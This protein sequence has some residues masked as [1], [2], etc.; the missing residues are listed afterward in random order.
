MKR[1]SQPAALP[2]KIL[3]ELA[4]LTDDAGRARFLARRRG[5]R[6][7]SVV[8]QL[9]DAART[10]LRIDT[11]RALSLAEAAVTIARKLRDEEALGRSLRAKANAL[12]VIGD[13]R[14]ALECHE[15]ALR[16]FR[17]ARNAEEEART[18]NASIQPLILLGDYDRALEA[19]EGARKLFRHLDDKRRLAHVEINVGNLYH[20]QDRFEEG[21]SFY[22]R[23]Y[24]MLLP[25]N[26]S[27]GLAVALYNMSVCLI[28]LNDFPRALS[29]YQRAREVFVERGMTLLIGQADYNI[30]Y[31]YYL[32]GEYGRAIDML[33]ATRQKS[34]TNGDAHILALCY[35][36]LSDIYLELN[37][38]AEAGEAAHEGYNRF[39][40]LAMGYEEAKCLANEAIALSQHGK[41]LRALDLF[42]R[43]RKVF[44]REKNLVWPWLI[45]LYRALVLFNEGRL[46]EARSACERALGFFES[47][48]LPGKAVLC[49]LL[50][51]RIELQAGSPE[52]AREHCGNAIRRLAGLEM[53]ILSYQA[54]LLMGQAHAAVRDVE[55]AYA[56]YQKAREAL[57]TLRSSLR[58]DE[59]KIAFMKNKSEV[60]ECLVAICLGGD[61]REPAFREAFGYIELAKSR[62][63]TEMILEGAQGSPEDLVC[64]SELVRRIRDMREELNWYYHRIELEQLRPAE[65]TPARIAQLQ[66]ATQAREKDLLRVLRELPAS[67]PETAALQ[68]FQGIPLDSIQ[69]QLPDDTSLIEYFTVGDQVIAA[70]VTRRSLEIVRVT[71]VSRIANLLQMLRAQLS[72]MC[73][74]AD[75]IQRF[76]GSLFQ[77][78]QSHLQA[79]HGE[80]L[81]PFRD[82][83][84]GKHVVFVPHGILHSLPFHALFD[85]QQYAIDLFSVSYAPSASVY[86]LCQNRPAQSGDA[87][88]V[89]G[90]PDKQAPSIL[91]EVSAVASLLKSPRVFVGEEATEQVLREHGPHSR[92]IHLATHGYF[93]N[94]SPMF[95]GIRLGN[96]HWS[97]LELHQLRLPAEL[98]ALS[99]CATGLN[100]VTAGDELLGLIRGLLAAGAQ[101]LLLSLWDVNDASSAQL[102]RLFYSRLQ[103]GETKAQA[104]RGAMQGLREEYPHPFYWAPFFLTGKA[105]SD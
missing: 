72:K 1:A 73:L 53:P 36:D 67:Q 34:E 81:A 79:L 71:L 91:D 94:D 65:N 52:S 47:S 40:K 77:A 101:C 4:N 85:G 97:L 102:M 93:R 105:V 82:R 99:G 78:T 10:Q 28:S 29:T 74:G 54:S 90:V 70:V 88:L 26:D 22:E 44:L 13:N 38:G 18:L 95:S 48:T 69:E 58:R 87:A 50:L 20:R 17:K 98:I 9:S 75:Y 7:A 46:F 57:E 11:G 43:A 5:L 104:L 42:A 45:D 35:L 61:K 63:L 23:A 66:K 64:Q 100:V 56:S 55:A 27:E 49:H 89:L 2:E 86:A 6:N 3:R 59:L 41:A 31:L 16:I 24:E 103:G 68:G 51:A 92:W 21:L 33:L 32:R 14:A 19:A 39:Q 80:L 83:I 15:Q 62:S 8:Q 84:T 25:F 60:Y 96:S 30:A 37:L 76:G 12:Y